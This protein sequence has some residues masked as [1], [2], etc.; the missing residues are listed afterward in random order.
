ME[1]AIFRSHVPID[2]GSRTLLATLALVAAASTA[3]VA[4]AADERAN[5]VADPRVTTLLNR[6]AAAARRMA[7]AQI[8]NLQRRLQALHGSDAACDR[9][10]PPPPRA[11]SAPPPPVE[12]PAPAALTLGEPPVASR[13]THASLPLASCRRSDVGT[14]WTGGAIE[15][16][17]AKA[18]GQGFGFHS[19]GVTLG[20]DRGLGH[21]LTLGVG[22]GVARDQDGSAA[23]GGASTTDAVA[24][25]AY[26]SYRPSNA[27]FIDAIAGYGDLQMSSLRRL[28]DRISFSGERRGSEQYAALAAGYRLDVGGADLAPYARFDALRATLRGYTETDGGVD[29]LRYQR[30]GV[31]ALKVAV[32]VE[33]SS[34][35][36][37]RL[38]NLSPRG[39]VE[40]RHE[41]DR[42]GAAPIGYADSASSAYAVDASESARNAVT[43]GFGAKLALRDSWSFDAGYTADFSSNARIDRFDFK[44]TRPLQ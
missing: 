10:A 43:T 37:T 12:R 25:A 2:R 24:A 5:P 35:I 21:G 1:T 30:Q 4:A 32:G 20:A 19:K 42:T 6:Q 17:S 15:I 8:A 22:V 14:A 33:G 18:E 13:P 31:P 41:W 40:L 3:G 16:G 34:R 11:A 23:E 27:L 39:R 26:L 9:P 44:L 38:G 7:A 29:A 28:D 36:E